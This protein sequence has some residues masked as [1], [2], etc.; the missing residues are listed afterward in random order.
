MSNIKEIKESAD[1]K[2]DK[3]DARRTHFKPPWGGSESQIQERIEHRKREIPRTLDQLSSDI[4][5]QK[6]LPDERKQ[7]VRSLVD[8]LNEQIA[9]SQTATQETLGSRGGRSERARK[10]RKPK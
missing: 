8:N 6:D 4:D 5:Q 2:L 10:K 3:L 7:A 1:V 9:L